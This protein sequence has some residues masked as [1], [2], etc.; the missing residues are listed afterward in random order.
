[1]TT[2]LAIV[3]CA[4]LIGVSAAFAASIYFVCQLV[5]DISK[6]KASAT[7]VDYRALTREPTEEVYPDIDVT[8]EVGGD[9]TIGTQEGMEHLR[10]NI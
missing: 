7:S 2:T 9:G 3:L 5:N 1:M 10:E 4:A 8:P 6:L